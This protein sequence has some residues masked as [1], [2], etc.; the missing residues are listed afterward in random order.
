MNLGTLVLIARSS[1]GKGREAQKGQNWNK[2]KGKK[3]KPGKGFGKKGKLNEMTE[4]D[5]DTWWWYES[6]WNGYTYDGSVD[7]I[8]Q[9]YED[10][11]QW[12]AWNGWDQP[13]EQTENDIGNNEHAE[14]KTVSEISKQEV[15]TVGSLVLSPLFGAVQED[16]EFCGLHVGSCLSPQPFCVPQPFGE[17]SEGSQGVLFERTAC[18]MFENESEPVSGQR[19]EDEFRACFPAP[20]QRLG[21]VR[22]QRRW[23][24][25]FLMAWCV[26]HQ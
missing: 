5:Y 22:S 24:K 7:H 15:K 23:M 25:S 9:G 20:G 1:G 16:M 4:A 3:G 10:S 14:A 18:E 11:W 13:W 21:L 2:G 12:D 8:S 17:G 26:K 19:G 6:D